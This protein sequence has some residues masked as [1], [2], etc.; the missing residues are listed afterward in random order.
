MLNDLTDLLA[1]A[2]VPA[3]KGSAASENKV[4]IN[5][6]PDKNGNYI[7][8][9]MKSDMQEIYNKELSCE[10]RRIIAFKMVK[11]IIPLIDQALEN[12]QA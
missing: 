3:K 8:N 1:K 10:K 4:S 5:L 2:E 6:I 7:E 11:R 9:G 12:S